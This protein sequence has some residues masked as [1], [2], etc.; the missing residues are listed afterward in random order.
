MSFLL[1]KRA[2]DADDFPKISEHFLKIRNIVKNCSEGQMN[3]SKHF[4][5]IS[6]HF[7]KITKDCQRRSYTNKF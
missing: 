1:Y 2:D 4:L 7:P 6:E 5:N 3:V